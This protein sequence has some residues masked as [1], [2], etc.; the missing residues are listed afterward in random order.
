MTRKKYQNLSE[1][2][3]N[4][5]KDKL[6]QVLSQL[7]EEEAEEILYESWRD[8]WA[9]PEQLF[10]DHW[11]EPYIL[12]Q[13]GRGA[14]KAVKVDEALITANRGWITVDDAEVGD[15]LFDENGEPCNITAIYEPTPEEIGYCYEFT[16]SD[17]TTLTACKDHQWVTWTHRDRKQF[18]RNKEFGD[19]P[20][21]NWAKWR[22]DIY[23]SRVPK[24][25]NPK[26]A[27]NREKRPTGDTYGSEIRTSEEIVQTF[28]QNTARKDLNHCIPVCKPLQFP[29]KHLSVDPYLYGYFL[30]DGLCN[31]SSFAIDP[32]DQG[33]FVDYCRSIGE[34]A[35]SSKNKSH[36]IVNVKG[37]VSKLKAIGAED[38]TYIPEE[39]LYNTEENRLWFLKGLL[40]SDGYTD[41]KLIEFCATRKHLAELVYY[42]AASLGQKPVLS[43]GRATLNGKDCGTKYRVMW[44]PTI[45]CFHLA[46]KAEKFN[47]NNVS[48]KSRQQHRMIKDYKKLPVQGRMKCFTVDSPNNMYLIGKNLIPTHNTR[49]GAEWI[50]EQVKKGQ[51]QIVLAA[52]TSKDIRDVMVLGPSGVISV[53]NPKDPDRPKYE[54]SKSRVTWPQSGAVAMMISGETPELFRGNNLDIAWMDEPG[55]FTDRD[56]FDQLALSLRRGISKMLITGTPRANELMIDLNERVGD[57]VKLLTS[58]TYANQQNLTDLFIKTVKKAYSGTRHEQ[59]ELEGKMILH[60]DDA[61]WNL[62]LLERATVP[63]DDLPNRFIKGAVAIDPAMSKNKHSDLTGIVL[64]LMG[65]DEKLYVMSDHSGKYS[66]SQWVGKAL[67]LYYEWSD[68]IPMTLVVERNQG[69]SMVKESITRQDPFVPVKD[70]FATTSKLARAEPIALLYEQGIVKHVKGGGLKDLENEMISFDGKG[71]KK[72]PDRM[73]ALVMACTQLRPTKK[74]FVVSHEFLI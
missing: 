62:D 35:E 42:L 68:K 48:Q 26:T 52:P 36:I 18:L 2:L 47:Y 69:G 12:F 30:G 51:R 56:P 16:F 57:D 40:D 65:D 71:K 58:S 39:Y 43:E 19:F 45:N 7:T 10:E 15:Q 14:G 41:G 72:S 38:K 44:T 25:F 49:A 29:E 46:R 24:G 28:R 54:P 6:A 21:E 1:V 61:L 67:G 9:R 50:K 23:E 3:R 13:G 27:K 63:E 11:E 22:G 5:P 32:Y 59:L 73:D 20:P 74:S 33:S 53:Y 8:I 17:K 70:V 66:T 64:V 4:M 34:D 55:S 31:T 60:S 37:F